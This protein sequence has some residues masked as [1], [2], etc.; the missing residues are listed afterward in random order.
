V[1]E[2]WFKKESIENLLLEHRTN[3]QD[4][5]VRLWMLLNLE[6]WHQLYIEGVERQALTEKLQALC[7]PQ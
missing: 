5:H 6:I 1:K 7:L 4:H 2:G 3:R